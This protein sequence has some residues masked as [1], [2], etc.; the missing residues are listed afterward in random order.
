MK[1]WVAAL[2]CVVLTACGST[3]QVRGTAA[4]GALSSEVT[5]ATDGLTVPGVVG[6]DGSVTTPGAPGTVSAPGTTATG[7]SGPAA[8]GSAAPGKP[9]APGASGVTPTAPAKKS[10]VEVGIIIF[11]DVNAAAARFGGSAAVGDQ[12]AEALAAVNWVNA[13]GGLDGHAITPVFFEVS[14][15]STQTYATTYQQICSSF[16]EDHHVV[17]TLL[18]GNA[19][20]GLPACLLKGKSLLL[21]HGHYLHDPSDFAA[22]PN[23]VTT[24]DAGSRRIAQA[25]VDQMLSKGLLK[26]GDKLGLLVMNYDGPRKARDEVIVPKLKAQGIEVV[27]YEVPYPQSTQD[28]SNSAAAVQSAQLRMAADGVKTVAF[29]CPG[30]VTFFVTDAESQGYYPRY[31]LTSYDTFS[32]YVG[33][34]HKQSFAGA[35]GIGFDPIRDVGVYKNATPLKGNDTFALCRSIEKAN[36]VDDATL[37]ASMAFCGE[38]LD[39]YAAAQAN[40]VEAL[41]WQSLAAGFDRLGTSHDGAANFATQ[42]GPNRRDGVAAFRTMHYDAETDAFAYDGG[43]LLPLP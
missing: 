22:F 21:A 11:P 19:E 4:G 29:L 24:E 13:H 31:V 12:K 42:L 5:G 2:S 41:T 8:R 37:F 36:I 30:C 38:V 18:V 20:A 16:T 27:S 17:A 23:L 15:T 26:R 6:T 25:M 9:A 7:S 35:L 34:G 33:K 10:K 40:P 14:L 39:L 3:V 28:V 32:G 43:G 1:W